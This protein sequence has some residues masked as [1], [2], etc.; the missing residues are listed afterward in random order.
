MDVYSIEIEEELVKYYKRVPMEECADEFLTVEEFDELPG[1]LTFRNYAADSSLY[2]VIDASA[3]QELIGRMVEA[4]NNRKEGAS[5][6]GFKYKFDNEWVRD[7]VY[8]K[9]RD[10]GIRKL[11]D[12]LYNKDHQGYKPKRKLNTQRVRWS[13]A[14]AIGAYVQSKY[15][16]PINPEYPNY[17][18]NQICAVRFAAKGMKLK[19]KDLLE[20]AN[21]KDTTCYIA[22]DEMLRD[23]EGKKYAEEFWKDVVKGK[24]QTK[25]E[26]EEEDEKKETMSEEEEQE[27]IKSVLDG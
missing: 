11:G 8:S 20:W 21:D 27:Y 4:Y 7:Y 22:Y 1:S 16:Y 18:D 3:C 26:Q 19:F 23:E 13:L 9:L 25:S 24:E 12:R 17:R 15:G 2:G 14:S 5:T 6:A 10:N